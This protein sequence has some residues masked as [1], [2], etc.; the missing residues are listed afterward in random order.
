[1]QRAEVFNFSP[2]V[3]RVKR[4]AGV[5]GGY[6][7]FITKDLRYRIHKSSFVTLHAINAEEEHGHTP[8]PAGTQFIP[9]PIR[10][11]KTTMMVFTNSAG[12]RI[13]SLLYY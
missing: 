7:Y 11:V 8:H 12:R 5:G 2:R 1:M 13:E 6:F 3:C 10:L 4:H 9:L